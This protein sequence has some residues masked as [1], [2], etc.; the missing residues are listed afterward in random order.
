MSNFT[1]VWDPLLPLNILAAIAAACV[2]VLALGLIA[3]R[4]GRMAP[5]LGWRFATAALLVAAL[6]NP[7]VIVEDREPLS[8]IAVV[9]VD[10]SLSQSIGDR[11]DDTQRALTAVEAKFADREA[12]ELRVVRVGRSADPASLEA[13]TEPQSG[14]RLFSALESAMAEVP[15]DRFAGALFITDGQVHDVPEVA[16][17]FALGGPL[18]VLL[19]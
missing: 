18:H 14:T 6:A 9:V 5:A 19:S 7:S 8:D 15:G 3:P 11:A 12:L 4:I 10:D 16:D 17:E 2:V 1:I 13:S